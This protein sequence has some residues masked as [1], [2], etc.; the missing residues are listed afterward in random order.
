MSLYTL[1]SQQDMAKMLSA[2]KYNPNSQNVYNAI[3]RD[4]GADAGSSNTS[5]WDNIGNFFKN[6]ASDIENA[7]GTTG[8]AIA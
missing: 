6:R 8:A 7:F 2:P 5:V 3:G 4:A 1:K